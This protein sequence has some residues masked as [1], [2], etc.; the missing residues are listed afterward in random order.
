VPK[1]KGPESQTNLFSRPPRRERTLEVWC[2]NC[3]ARFVAWYG[4]EEDA[5]TETVDVEKCGLCGGDSFKKDVF[6]DTAIRLI[7]QVTARNVKRDDQEGRGLPGRKGTRPFG[8][9]E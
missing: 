3:Q 2:G 6:K 9:A 4:T 5:D 7:A 8:S 1:R